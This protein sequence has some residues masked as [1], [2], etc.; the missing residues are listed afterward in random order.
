VLHYFSFPKYLSLYCCVP[1][2]HSSIFLVFVI[3]FL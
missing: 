2:D 3:S 1:H